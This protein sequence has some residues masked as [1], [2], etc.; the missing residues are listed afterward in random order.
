MKIIK[1]KQINI[2]K[3]KSP[4][5]P[6]LKNIMIYINVLQISSLKKI[7]YLILST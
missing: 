5:I 6:I 3:L 7:K 4:F 2:Y 1:L